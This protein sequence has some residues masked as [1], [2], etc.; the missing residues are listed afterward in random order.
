MSLAVEGCKRKKKPHL[1]PLYVVKKQSS[2]PSEKDRG[3]EGGQIYPLPFFKRC[4]GGGEGMEREIGK[5]NE[6]KSRLCQ[7]GP[8][9]GGGG[10]D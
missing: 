4:G 7:A 8:R 3:G 10:H 1:P 9:R 2:Y 5:K 6:D